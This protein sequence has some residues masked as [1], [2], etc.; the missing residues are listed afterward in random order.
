MRHV[1]AIVLLSVV[2]ALP[3][4]Q[5]PASDKKPAQPQMEIEEAYAPVEGAV[6]FTI[7]PLQS[8]GEIRRWLATYVDENGT[9]KF[10]LELGPA[11]RAEGSISST[12]EGSFH[13][14][15]GSNPLV[16]LEAL[17][18]ALKARRTPSSVQQADVVPFTYAMLGEGQS[19]AKDGSYSTQ[20]SG[21]WT[22]MK[23]SLAG[24]RGI[25]RLNLDPSAHQGE[26]VREDA[27]Y[28]DVLLAELAKVL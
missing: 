16:L 4:C 9:T 21:Q 2:A 5:R 26:F 19:R 25:V 20:A 28:G 7:F 23:I 6:G 10:S 11:T 24:G 13:A 17:Q 3:G 27:R 8:S 14:E 22:T 1:F 15:A 12:G 18:K